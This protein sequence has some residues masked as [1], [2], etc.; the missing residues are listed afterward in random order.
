MENKKEELVSIIMPAYNCGDFIGITLDSVI[1]QIY[2]NWELLVV[3]D[4]ST[5]NTSQ[6]VKEYI[7]KDNRIKYHK[8]DKNS[9]AAVE[10]K[11]LV[12]QP[13]NIWLS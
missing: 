4:C 10:T 2:Q 9:G 3:D 11:L 6:V 5:D 13:V 1:N 7:K 8:L 12:L